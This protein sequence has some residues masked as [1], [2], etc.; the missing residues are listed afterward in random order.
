MADIEVDWHTLAT[1]SITWRGLGQ[2]VRAAVEGLEGAPTAGF[3]A[4]CAPTV[5]AF[6]SAWAGSTASLA[7]D[8]E[9]LDDDLQSALTDFGTFE[10]DVSASLDGTAK[11][12]G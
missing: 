12:C 3:D 7:T 8:A 10:S 6:L 5:S 4:T 9:Q 2:D 1:A 11:E